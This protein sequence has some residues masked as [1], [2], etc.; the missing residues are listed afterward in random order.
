MAE[1]EFLT[2]SIDDYLLS[3]AESVCQ[4]QRQLS[5]MRIPGQ[6][7]QSATMYQ[8]PRVDFEL[9]MSFEVTQSDA[10]GD[11][12]MMGPQGGRPGADKPV[13]LRA[14]PA[15]GQNK[16]ARDTSAE[17]ASI[18][19][20]SFVAVPAQGGKPPP[21]IR[22]FLERLSRHELKIRV[23][24]RSAVGEVLKD[25]EVQFNVDRDLS[26]RLNEADS[27]AGPRKG[28]DLLY[29]MV[30]TDGEGNALNILKV[31]PNELNGARAA[32]VI[33]LLGETETILFQVEE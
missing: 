17:A 2:A 19:K 21:M 13:A 23:E 12:S 24:V 7:G 6:F 28:T 29:S 8:L 31:D 15:G 32:V 18:I 16:G 9:K 20:G 26:R 3:L 10:P 4:A 33:D 1:E 14:R 11:S 5:Q 30:R 25:V 22:T 27:I